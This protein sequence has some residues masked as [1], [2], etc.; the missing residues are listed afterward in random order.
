MSKEKT[1]PAAEQKSDNW[2]TDRKAARAERRAARTTAA[3]MGD[4]GETKKA[5]RGNPPRANT[6]NTTEQEAKR[7]EKMTYKERLNLFN[8]N[9]QQYHKLANAIKGDKK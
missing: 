4:Q 1:G 2:R 8:S 6:A 5:L 9:P 7:F 3:P